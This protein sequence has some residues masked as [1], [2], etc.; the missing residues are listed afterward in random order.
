MSKRVLQILAA[1]MLAYTSRASV[2]EDG[3]TWL[4][5][6][7]YEPEF[8]KT[9]FEYFT[10]EVAGDTVV[11][12]LP[13]KKILQ[14]FLNSDKVCIYIVRETD[15]VIQLQYNVDNPTSYVQPG[16]FVDIMK[17]NLSDGE[18]IKRI[19]ALDGY[20]EEFLIASYKT[21]HIINGRECKEFSISIDFIPDKSITCLLEDV[22]ASYSDPYVSWITHFWYT[23]GRYPKVLY[24]WMIECRKNG[25]LIFSGSEFSVPFEDAGI[26]QIEAK[27]EQENIFFNLQGYRVT[28]PQKGKIYIQNNRKILL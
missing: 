13:A 8:F 7:C 6:R 28:V 15:G 3:K 16:D 23:D 19:S 26:C 9:S 17:F 20:D 27:T 14:R 12:G 4:M 24:T 21:T 18:R 2:I 25:R 5:G 11:N 1:L 10:A 22:G